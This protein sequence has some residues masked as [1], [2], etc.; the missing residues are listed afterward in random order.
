MSPDGKHSYMFYFSSTFLD[1]SHWK[2]Y[3]LRILIVYF[4]QAQ[5]LFFFLARS[6]IYWSCFLISKAEW[7]S[8]L[9]EFLVLYTCLLCVHHTCLS[10]WRSLLFTRRPP[11]VT[12]VSPADKTSYQGWEG[13]GRVKMAAPLDDMFSFCVEP[14]KV[15]SGVE[16]KF[17]N[18]VKVSGFVWWSL[19]TKLRLKVVVRRRWS[20]CEGRN[21]WAQKVAA[22]YC[23]KLW[24]LFV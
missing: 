23:A 15:G 2:T 16:V 8:M 19:R 24:H 7:K 4:K 12:A 3:F 9:N 22:V 13:K 1:F 18:N 20:L 21:R 5:W 14:G 6:C 17:I 11:E 10:T